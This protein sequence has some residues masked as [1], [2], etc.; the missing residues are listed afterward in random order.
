LN[1]VDPRD[2][3]LKATHEDEESARGNRAR[4]DEFELEF[5]RVRFPYEDEEI[6]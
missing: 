1:G 6:G 2:L 5:E 4:E 3:P